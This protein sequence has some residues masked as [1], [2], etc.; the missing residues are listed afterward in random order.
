MATHRLTPQQLHIKETL[1]TDCSLIKKSKRHM[2]VTI[3]FLFLKYY[4]RHDRKLSS[5]STLQCLYDTVKIHVKIL[6]ILKCL[7]TV[8]FLGLYHIISYYII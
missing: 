7:N 5:K 4:Q 2:Q 6:Q 8:Q 3:L 1:I